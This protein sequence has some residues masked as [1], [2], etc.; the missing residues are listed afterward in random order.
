MK[1]AHAKGHS[2][3]PS[4]DLPHRAVRKFSIDAIWRRAVDQALMCFGLFEAI[5]ASL[6]YRGRSGGGLT[7][8]ELA[9]WCELAGHRWFG[10]LIAFPHNLLVSHPQHF[11][12]A[13]N[14]QHARPGE[15][16]EGEACFSSCSFLWSPDH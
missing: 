2:A 4:E 6:V 7:Q 10:F 9:A 11:K 15:R 3:V 16:S 13:M 5:A 12:S 8:V 1:R 14:E